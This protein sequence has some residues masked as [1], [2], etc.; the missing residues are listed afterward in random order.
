MKF[1]VTI[2]G[3]SSATPVYNRNPTAQLLN[4]NEKFYLI[5]CGEGT[6]QQLIRYGFKA[7]KIDYIFISHLHGDHYFGLIGLLSSLHLNGRMKPMHIFAPAALLE[8]L[9]LQFRHSETEIRYPI[10][11]V[12]TQAEKPEQIFENADLTVES[13]VLNHR[14]PCTGFSFVQK[15][16]LRKLIIEKLE[17]EQIPIEYYTLLKRGVDLDLPDG[18]VLLNADYTIDSDRPKKYS[19]CSDTLMD[20]CYL[21]NIKDCDTLYHEATFLHEMLDRANQTHHTT[22]LQAAQIA[23]STGAAKLLIGHF[24]SRYKSLQPLLDEART[25]FQNTELAIEGITYRI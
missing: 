9:T 20:E 16:R 10:E 5:D 19:Y 8:I 12:A 24:S 22:A 25:E 11:F 18:N 17:A 21:D 13:F 6:Q 2:L 14:I 1:E 4:C 3:S 15:K 23:K 7:N